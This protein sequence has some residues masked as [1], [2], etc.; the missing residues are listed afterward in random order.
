MN[1]LAFFYFLLPF[2]S[3]YIAFRYI[4][5]DTESYTDSNG[6]K[7]VIHI[8]RSYRGY[9]TGLSKVFIKIP[10]N[11]LYFDIRRVDIFIRSI[12]KIERYLK[13]ETSDKGFY[14]D[15]IVATD[16]NDLIQALNS[17]KDI[18][19]CI[20]VLFD[21][22]SVHR[23]YS[24]GKHLAVKIT[25]GNLAAFAANGKDTKDIYES[26][27]ALANA[28]NEPAPFLKNGAAKYN[29]MRILNVF[30]SALFFSSTIFFLLFISGNTVPR[31]IDTH[32]LSTYL[33]FG[34]VLGIIWIFLIICFFKKTTWYPSLFAGLFCGFAGCIFFVPSVALPLNRYLDHSIGY[35]VTARIIGKRA[36]KSSDKISIP[37]HKEILTTPISSNSKEFILFSSNQLFDACKEGD[38]VNITIKD[39]YLSSP[40]VVEEKLK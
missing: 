30:N 10:V 21:N 22:F 34:F 31:L 29:T 18:R 36:W 35:E 27:Y 32:A 24:N 38:F 26:L 9:S 40:W 17:R 1:Y 4:F 33:L 11:N 12:K 3:S 2:F 6:K 8:W 19:D 16:N 15:F 28:L 7:Y 25:S 14:N 39:G 13:P 23:L 37:A 20:R 5:T